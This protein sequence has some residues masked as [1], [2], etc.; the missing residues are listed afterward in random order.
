[1]T[2]SMGHS[3]K[4]EVS[5]DATTFYE[6]KG[7]S[8]LSMS[9]AYEE[10]ERTTYDS[11][12]DKDFDLGLEDRTISLSL[13]Y[14]E[15]NA[16]QLLLLDYAESRQPLYYRY[17][18]RRYGRIFT[19]RVLV[20]SL[21]VGA[22]PDEA[23]TMDVSL[24]C[25]PLDYGSP[26][27][28]LRFA[29]TLS[30]RDSATET[31][32][33][34]FIRA[35]SGSYVGADGIIKYAAP[36]EPR[37]DHDPTTGESLGLLIEEQRTNFIAHSEELT[38][39]YGW[40]GTTTYDASVVAPDGTPGAHRPDS[41]EIT[42]V[43]PGVSGAS[44]VSFSFFVRP[45]SGLP[46]LQQIEI[47]TS[48]TAGPNFASYGYG[49]LFDGGNTDANSFTGIKVV[50]YS[51]GW[52]RIS[53]TLTP[54]TAFDATAR[55]DFNQ[56]GF[57]THHIW[58]VQVEVGAFP[59][60]YIPTTGSQATRNVDEA[61]VGFSSFSAFYGGPEPREGS[62]IADCETYQTTAGKEVSLFEIWSSFNDRWFSR[63]L[64]NLVYGYQI[65]GGVT[66][67][68]NSVSVANPRKTYAAFSSN[69]LI[70]G[71]GSSYAV[72]PWSHPYVVI[73]KFGLEITNFFE[74]TLNGHYK[75]FTFYPTRLP[76]LHL[77]TL[78]ED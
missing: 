74:Q 30:L 66:L 25:L 11:T 17:T 39:A 67:A 4:F 32:P 41:A 47:F 76:N 73:V 37:F 72:S 69:E 78:T 54:P 33:V 52:L 48:T 12:G 56:S 3:A 26:S 15:D 22:T 46:R 24:R 6:V 35:T 38:N 13:F 49:M 10:H 51:N 9:R 58:G 23:S 77:Q 61:Y 60:S 21:E 57:T 28:D 65:D 29:D 50:P 14:D 27:L 36:G 63:K 45:V 2:V 55:F 53:G 44:S 70:L 16:A 5:E 18:Q 20:T 43:I 19:G 1:M 64:G 68:V 7:I 62:I 71:S 31:Y 40:S 8:D 34:T 75:R 42:R 59:T